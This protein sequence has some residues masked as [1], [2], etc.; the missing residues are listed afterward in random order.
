MS[1]SSKT[2]QDELGKTAI[3]HHII[4]CWVAIILD[5]LWAISDYFV[6]PEYFIPF[7]IIRLLVA[8][9]TF[10]GLY[11][12]QKLSIPMVAFIPVLGISL[13][14]A[15]MYNVMEIGAFQQHTFAYIALFIGAGMLVF[16]K[17][18]YTI[19]VVGLSIIANF[20]L[21][22]LFSPLTVDEF[23]INGGLLTMTVGLFSIILIQT[24][25]RL[26]KKEIIARFDLMESKKELEVKNEI[27][28][29]KN[30]NITDSIAYAQN[31]QSAIL[32]NRSEIA[33][34][35]KDHF[36]FFSPKDV[37]SGDFYW[38]TQKANKIFI[39]VCD[40]TGHGVP[41]AFVSMI[42]NNLLNQVV[43]ERNKE[44]PGEILSCL[45][46]GM[47]NAFTK[48][49]ELE[50][51]DGMDM[52]LLVFE[53]DKATNDIIKL[54][55]SGA[56]NPSYLIR[57]EIA[58]SALTQEDWISEFEEHF[59]EIKGDKQAIGGFTEPDYCFHTREIELEKGDMVYAFS[60][61]YMDQF[62]GPK[63]KKF[64]KK[65]FKKLFVEFMD[66]EMEEQA[67]KMDQSIKEW[68][69]EE[70]QVDDI[71]VIGIKV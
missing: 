9:M 7:L 70:E 64:M 35:L 26:T 19:V 47:I 68:M 53:L 17:Q 55:Y 57:K 32:P 71:L 62:G 54:N 4:V 41:G 30:K 61:G 69:G 37:V 60:D 56:N 36:I 10:L 12:R 3:K 18:I 29:E 40:C 8:G 33:K 14:N 1:T 6:L 2:W 28:E 63:G 13:Q 51:K 39:A 15:Y 49:G 38:F 24:R 43:I 23:L 21:F 48:E 45:N 31:I 5:P 67:E 59:V 65:N 20:V 66:L 11:F 52:A 27:I 50:A 42:G 22:H 25:Y 34:Y 44:D 58:N 16:W 46:Q